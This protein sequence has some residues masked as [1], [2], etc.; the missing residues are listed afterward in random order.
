MGALVDARVR[1]S[2]KRWMVRGKV[3]QRDR[4]REMTSAASQRIFIL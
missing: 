4:F 1:N 3:K 2:K